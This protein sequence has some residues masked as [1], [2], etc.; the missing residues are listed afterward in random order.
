MSSLI[1]KT[2]KW[3]D[4]YPLRGGDKP[5]GKIFVKS[6]YYDH[7]SDEEYSIDSD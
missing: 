5:I 4:M 7:D 6:F 1:V 3:H 2:E